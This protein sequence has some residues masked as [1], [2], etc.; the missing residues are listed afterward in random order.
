MFECNR[1]YLEPTV[2][3]CNANVP[4]SQRNNSDYAWRRGN[5]V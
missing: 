3:K 5:C 2:R 4:D 1:L